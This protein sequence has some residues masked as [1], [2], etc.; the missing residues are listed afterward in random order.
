MASH[1][2]IDGSERVVY[3]RERVLWTRELMFKVI[4]AMQEEPLLWNTKHVHFKHR[5]KKN[6]A[7]KRVAAQLQLPTEAVRQKWDVLKSSYHKNRRALE[8]QP[9]STIRWF[10]F[11]RLSFLAPAGEVSGASDVTDISTNS[12]NMEAT[13][14]GSQTLAESS[15]E[16][17]T[18]IPPTAQETSR[19]NNLSG[20]E[21][22]ERLL[23]VIEEGLKRDNN[24][25]WSDILGSYVSMAVKNAG[26]RPDTEMRRLY[27]E[28][29]RLMEKFQDGG[30]ADMGP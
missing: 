19:P 17:G 5:S 2:G 10:A 28:I 13:Y 4:D 20:G 7:L 18:A 3:E 12:E 26:N 27:K 9:A 15:S 16:R 14:M 23:K 1:N 22:L 11:D 8:S 21:I 29:I 30:L 6:A 24:P 25:T